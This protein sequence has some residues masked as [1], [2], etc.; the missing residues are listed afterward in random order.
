M[1]S[2]PTLLQ[3]RYQIGGQL[4][5]GGMG[6]VYEA[7]D[8]RLNTQVAIKETQTGDERLRRQFEREARMLAGLRHSGLPRVIDHF[9]E[10]SSLYLV[11]DYIPGPDL[12]Q[13]LTTKGEPFE[14]SQVMEWADQLLEILRYVHGQDPQIIHRDIKPQNLKLS[15]TGH[16]ILLD[17]G[18]A[19]GHTGPITKL[20]TTGSI[21]G[22][23]P[24]YAPL[25]QIQGTGTDPRSDLYS[26]AATLYHLLSGQI[27]ND[28]L[29]RATAILN[30]EPDPLQPINII[31]P[32]I[33]ASVGAVLKQALALKRDER[34]ASAVEMRQQLLEAMQRSFSYE[35]NSQPTQILDPTVAAVHQ[36]AAPVTPETPSVLTSPAQK[37]EQLPSGSPAQPHDVVPE[38]QKT[39]ALS[40]F[41]HASLCGLGIG[42]L[43]AGVLLIALTSNLDGLGVS[44]WLLL[45]FLSGGI[46][47][48]L[49]ILRSPNQLTT[50][51]VLKI[52][53]V[54]GSIIALIQWLC[55][56]VIHLTG[57]L[58][59]PVSN[60]GE[61]FILLIYL[62]GF[63][64]GISPVTGVIAARFLKKV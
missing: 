58:K 39:A 18:L 51:D 15:K 44:A 52:T 62:L 20:T 24:H 16:L 61:V 27:P 41:N 55:L 46:V 36:S 28:A 9:N 19:K 59:L 21:F 38:Q 63:M 5:K 64:L 60:S 26:L 45:L 56:T 30:G 53:M 17:F 23:T 29:S 10:G 35:P 1:T 40:K 31:N 3:N 7:R 8:L 54:S 57:F 47:T 50:T 48:L 13:M 2:P 22:Y 37:R 43:T 14:V 6:T 33:S 34:P 4:G 11:M 25:E 32:Q 12:W 49:Y 42:I